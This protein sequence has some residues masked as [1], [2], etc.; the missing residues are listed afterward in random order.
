MCCMRLK[1]SSKQANRGDNLR[2]GSSISGRQVQTT[3]SRRSNVEAVSRFEHLVEEAR[4]GSAVGGNTRRVAGAD[5]ETVLNGGVCHEE[6]GVTI[7]GE[8]WDVDTLSLIRSRVATHHEFTSIAASESTVELGACRGRRVLDE[9]GICRR[10][11]ES[12]RALH[13][14]VETIGD[15]IRAG[16]HEEAEQSII[17]AA[18]SNARSSIGAEREAASV[19]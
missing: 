17:S 10:Q 15:S 6:V 8:D 9:T 14:R 13:S 4:R 16:L 7:L 18:G 3:T 11:V 19:R 5:V 1:C 12:S 2:A